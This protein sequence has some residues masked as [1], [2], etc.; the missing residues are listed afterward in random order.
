MRGKSLDRLLRW[1]PWQRLCSRHPTERCL[2]TTGAGGAV[3]SALNDTHAA[4]SRRRFEF[5]GELGGADPI[6]DAFNER[7]IHAAHE[8]GLFVGERM[9]RAVGEGDAVPVRERLEAL[10]G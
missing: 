1:H 3:H 2:V 10:P 4:L 6:E 7:K 8:V 9:E 5:R